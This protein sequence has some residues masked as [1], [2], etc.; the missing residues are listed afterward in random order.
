[1]AEYYK[2][3][4]ST[5][6]SLDQPTED[7][8][9]NTN[10]AEVPTTMSQF[11][12]HRESLISA[13]VEEGWASELRRY[14]GTMQRDVKKDTDIVEWWQVSK[15]LYIRKLSILTNTRIML[16]YFRHSHA[17]H[18]MSSLLKR[19]LCHVNGCSRVL[20]KLQLTAVPA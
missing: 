12:K 11:D 4:P 3:W 18:L 6:T 17:S 9:N 13:D 2:T 7:P 20:S 8:N 15:T 1:M 10:V 14:I 19:H 16:S 5:L